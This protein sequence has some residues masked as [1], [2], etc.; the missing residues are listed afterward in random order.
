MAKGKTR[1]VF[2]CQSCGTTHGRW[3]GQC[4]GCGE[5]NTIAEEPVLQAASATGPRAMSNR[6]AVV[7][8]A[9]K[10]QPLPR[11]K[12]GIKEFDHVCGGGLVPGGCI[13]IGGD[14]G[15]GK[16][17]LLLQV[18]ARAA[19][20]SGKRVLYVSGEEGVSQVRMRA[21]RLGLSEAEVDLA[22]ATGVGEI[23]AG[24]SPDYALVVIDSIQTMA[25]ETIE[26]APGTVSQ[27]KGAGHELNQAAKKQN[28]PV[29]LVGH[30]TKDGSIA[31]P[32]VLEHLVD[33]VLY[34]EGDRSHQYRILRA[35][36]NRFGPTDEIGVFEMT[37]LGLAEV[38]N[39]SAM[40]LGA[41]DADGPAVSGSAVFAGIEGTRPL[42]VEIQALVG[43]PGVA[44][45][46]RTAVGWDSARL[47]MV[48]AVLETRC[49]YDFQGR[50]VF[51][52]VAGGLRLAEPAADLAAAAALVS[53]L[54]DKP[55]PRDV[56]LFGEVG[57]SGEL[58]PV[59]QESARLREAERLGFGRALAALA[60]KGKSKDKSKDAAHGALA[61]IRIPRLSDLTE[62]LREGG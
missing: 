15:I 6:L 32:R 17:T 19:A 61:S 20:A 49:L 55:V 42:L 27:V 33:T 45:P 48:L 18:A 53:A 2:V 14:P 5:W 4:T 41:R 57:L 43:Q 26:S 28:V 36:K 37:G 10:E 23:C 29:V 56:V 40:F 58:R 8:L 44:T 22:S 25:V 46:R 11:L 35:V 1:A 13:L 12:T 47:S 7:A 31:G 9:G 24:I 34:F 30:V 39:P 54:L 50:D 51:L 3:G 52:N 59:G 38:P 60:D 21:A 62:W 16:S